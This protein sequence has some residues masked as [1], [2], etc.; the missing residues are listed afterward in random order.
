MQNANE[1]NVDVSVRADRAKQRNR[2]GHRLEVAAVSPEPD[3]PLPT[4]SWRDFFRWENLT[5]DGREVKGFVVSPQIAGIFLVAFLGMLGWA[6]KSTTADSRETLKAITRMETLLE[7]RTR[8]FER[9]Q[10]KM[11]ERFGSVEA[12]QQVTNKEIVKL[13]LQRQ[14]TQ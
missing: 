5:V 1:I 2:N 12:W 9:G 7:E 10:D 8:T 4:K 14:G 6:Y 11:E 13:Q 3:A